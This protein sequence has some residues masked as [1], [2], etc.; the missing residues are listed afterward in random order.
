M[1]TSTPPR[2]HADR[3]TRPIDQIARDL[4]LGDEEW[5]P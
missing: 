5:I 3:K 2:P 1:P 4:G